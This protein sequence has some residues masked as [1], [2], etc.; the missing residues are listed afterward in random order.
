MKLCG[1]LFS[2]AFTESKVSGPDA[3]GTLKRIKLLDEDGARS[4][5]RWEGAEAS[6]R[7]GQQPWRFVAWAGG[8]ANIRCI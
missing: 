3:E 5:E 7:S 2:Q 8:V 1:V 4:V 6:A